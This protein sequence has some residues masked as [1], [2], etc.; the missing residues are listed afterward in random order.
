MATVQMNQY[1]PRNLHLSDAEYLRSGHPACPGC[2]AALGLRMALKAL[3]EKTVVV[4]PASCFAVCVGSYPFS[5]LNVPV[6][7]VAFATAAISAAGI[8]AGL[9]VQGN[10]DVAVLV[11]AGDGGTFDIGLQSLSGTVER[12]DNIIYVCYDN[13]AYMNTGIQRSSATPYG[14]WTTT[15]PLPSPK[16]EPKKDII[17]ILAEH[18]IPYAATAS[19]AFPEDFARKLAKAKSMPGTKFLHLWVACPTGHKSEERLSIRIA[20]LAVETGIFPLYEVE[21]GDRYTINWEPSFRDV[22]EY[23][24]PQGRFRHLTEEQIGTIRGNVRAEWKHLRAKVRCGNE[25]EREDRWTDDLLVDS[26]AVAAT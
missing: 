19:I 20:R 18:R 4:I 23:L 25:L 22:K 9:D 6:M 21:N 7:N 11:W 16:Q 13:E 3:G 17:G 12:N 14:A 10:N 2:G 26:L 24:G 15:T 1:D 8:R 5:A